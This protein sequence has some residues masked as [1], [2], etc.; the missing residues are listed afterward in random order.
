MGWTRHQMLSKKKSDV[1]DTWGCGVGRLTTTA[2]RVTPF[3]PNGEAIMHLLYCFWKSSGDT[4]V[5][6]VAAAWL[7][8]KRQ[9]LEAM[10]DGPEQLICRDQQAAEEVNIYS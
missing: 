3:V 4:S 6:V 5:V 2:A 10:S 9:T 1:S 7:H 8:R